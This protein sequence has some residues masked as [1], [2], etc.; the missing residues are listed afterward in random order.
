MEACSWIRRSHCSSAL[1]L[2]LDAI[3][4]WLAA[5]ACGVDKGVGLCGCEWL[6]RVRIRFL[7]EL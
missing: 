5:V 1:E 3:C 7:Q 4:G 6:R 2:E